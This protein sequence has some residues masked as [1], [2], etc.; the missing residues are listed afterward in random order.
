MAKF[1][2]GPIGAHHYRVGELIGY[3]HD[4]LA[5]DTVL[6]DV[7]ISGEMVDV[8]RSSAGHTYFTLRDDDARIGVVLF[9]MAARRQAVPLS[10]GHS[11]LVHG[12]VNIYEQRSIYQLVADV[13]LPGDTGR[14]RAQFEALRTRLEREGLFAPERKRT[15]PTM[16]RRIG[17]VTSSTGAAIHDILRVW[18]RRFPL[19]E[20][21]LAPTPVQGEE[22]LQGIV[23]ALDRLNAFHDERRPLDFI[24]LARGGGAPEELAVF[25]EEAIAR[26]IFASALP[27]VSAIGHEVDWTIAD[28]VADLR[29]PTPSAAAEMV[30]PD[31]EEL[32]RQVQHAADRSRMAMRRRLGD[33]QSGS[34]SLETRLLRRSPLVQIQNGRA[35]TDELAARG[36]RALRSGLGAARAG[37]ETGRFRL[38]ALNPEAILARGYALCSLP[39]SGAL[40]TDA[41]QV[42]PGDRVDIR[43]ARGGVVSEVLDAH[44]NIVRDGAGFGS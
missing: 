26:A 15:L 16:P 43:L 22:A 30:V 11:A 10:E 40:L 17:L 3:L 29:A 23:M 18:E 13:V 8:T 33:A 4:L 19:L 42:A 41:A 2:T 25:N 44:P 28:L 7:W 34:G 21:I 1:A 12:A 20:V 24:I 31:V 35:R 36:M 32:R 27:V 39:A 5:S 9:R 38:G 37:V 14:M 6:S